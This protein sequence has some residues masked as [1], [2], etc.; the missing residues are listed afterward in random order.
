MNKKL[1]YLSAVT[2]VALVFFAGVNVGQYWAFS[3]PD[4]YDVT[5]LVVIAV[6]RNGEII[7]YEVSVNTVVTIGKKNVRN[8]LGW[9]NGTG[10]CKYIALSNDATPLATWTKLPNEITTGGLDRN[11]GT[12]KYINATAYKV[13]YEFTAT[14]GAT[15][16][17]SGLHWS[18][19]DDSDNNL[20]AANTFTQVTLAANDKIKITWTVNCS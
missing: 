12:V 19:T 18:A 13:E 5:G 7:Y 1:K 4:E 15:V 3:V 20:F 16:Q 2:I 9:D 10:A 17:C 6:T 14:A 8:F 11:T